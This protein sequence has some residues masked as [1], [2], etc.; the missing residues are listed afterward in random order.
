MASA[1]AAA[2]VFSCDTDDDRLCVRLYVVVIM[3]REK[4]RVCRVV[5]FIRERV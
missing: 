2:E 5:F 3:A 1:A 4:L